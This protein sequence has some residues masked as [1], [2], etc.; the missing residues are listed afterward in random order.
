[1]A[2]N[3]KIPVIVDCDPG[4]DDAIAIML[5]A[6]RPEFDIKGIV[7]VAGNQI[8]DNTTKNAQ[9]ILAFIGRSDIPVIRGAAKPILQDCSPAPGH[10][11][12]G[13]DGPDLPEPTVAPVDINV[14]EFYRQ[15]LTESEVPVVLVPIGPLTNIAILLHCHPELKD[16]IAAVN[17]MGG[18]T[19]KQAKEYS[20]IRRMVEFNIWHDAYAAQMVFDAGVP[21][22]LFG[23]DVTHKGGA[24]DSDIAKFKAEGGRVGGLIAA[25]L[26]FYSLTYRAKGLDVTPV[27]DVCPV[28]YMIDPTIFGGELHQIQMDL[29]GEHTFG[30]TICDMRLPG[31]RTRRPF[32]N[33]EKAYVNVITSVDRKKVL[34]L[35]M[36]AA[37]YYQ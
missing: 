36:E 32:E 5:L 22:N 27:H 18:G 20:N 3:K 8:L 6:S 14:I 21:I 7:T 30:A 2:E 9:K 26:E 28:A 33:S 23:L 31:I 35:I 15:V 16:K 11:K 29:K 34:D 37:K 10:G 25:L 13:L 1:M 19:Y 4:H 12:S 17:I 24:D